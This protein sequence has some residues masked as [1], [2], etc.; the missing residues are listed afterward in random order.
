VFRKTHGETR[1][2][3][4][5]YYLTARDNVEIGLIATAKQVEQLLKEFAAYPKRVIEKD[6]ATIG[7]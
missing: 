5:I 4:H 6:K 1:A 2:A 7:R 3:N